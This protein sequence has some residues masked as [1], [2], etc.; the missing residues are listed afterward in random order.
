VGTSAASRLDL[1]DS[2][3]VLAALVTAFDLRAHAPKHLADRSVR[4]YLD[5]S[6]GGSDLARRAHA[7]IGEALLAADLTPDSARCSS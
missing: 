6:R 3:R 5:G 7:A 4:A 1:P 2:Q